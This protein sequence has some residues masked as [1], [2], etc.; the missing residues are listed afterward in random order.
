MARATPRRSPLIS[1]TPAVSIATSVPVPMAMPTSAWA[2]AGAS[3]MPSPTM[4]TTVRPGPFARR[5]WPRQSRCSWIAL[6]CAA[7]SPGSTSASTCVDAHLAGDRFGRAPVVA[8]QH[9]HRASPSRRR[10]AMASAEPSLTVSA[11]PMAPTTAAVDGG[12][13]PPSCLRPAA[14]RP[15][16]PIRSATLPSAA[17]QRGVP[18]STR[19][20]VHLGAD[21]V[22]G[23][24]LEALRLA[25]RQPALLRRLDDGL[26]QRM[27]RAR[28]RPTRSGAEISACLQSLFGRP[29]HVRHRRLA[30][31]DRAGLVQH[32]RPA[33][34]RCAPAPPSCGTGCRS[35]RPCPCRP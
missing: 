24:G 15:L 33:P 11:M 27:L 12:R 6:T 5:S 2:S 23:H 28:A 3:L 8:G 25:E 21:A 35:P 19:V 26:P 29:D 4:A 32:D 20:T 7:L 18:T 10:L 14:A 34:A 17:S 31:R 1:V 16:R 22:P 9:D 13:P 30:A